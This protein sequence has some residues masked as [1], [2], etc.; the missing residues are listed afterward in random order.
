MA[1]IITIISVLGIVA[2]ADYA[3]KSQRCKNNAKGYGKQD[4]KKILKKG[5][6]DQEFIKK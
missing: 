1:T 4:L 3:I 5:L 6:L 2:I